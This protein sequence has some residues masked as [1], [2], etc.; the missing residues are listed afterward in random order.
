MAAGMSRDGEYNAKV[1]FRKAFLSHQKTFETNKDKEH[2]LI[3]DFDLF[4]EKAIKAI[5]AKQN[6]F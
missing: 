1:F 2:D 5:S 4:L 3:A 6:H